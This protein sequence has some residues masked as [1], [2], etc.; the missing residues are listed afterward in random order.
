M[1]YINS[2]IMS[3]E[4]LVLIEPY[5]SIDY[6]RMYLTIQCGIPHILTVNY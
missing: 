6:C 2:I 1:L 4:I 3:S 5:I